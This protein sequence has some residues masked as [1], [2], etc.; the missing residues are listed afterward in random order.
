[1]LHEEILYSTSPPNKMFVLACSLPFKTAVVIID[2]DSQKFKN[3]IHNNRARIQQEINRLDLKSVDDHITTYLAARPAERI[4][5]IAHFSIVNVLI[6]ELSLKQ[7]LFVRNVTILKSSKEYYL[8]Y[9]YSLDKRWKVEKSNL[10]TFMEKYLCP[11]PDHMTDFTIV[12][13]ILKINGRTYKIK[14]SLTSLPVTTS[15]VPLLESRCV[16]SLYEINSNSEKEIYSWIFEFDPF[17]KKN[18]Y[19]FLDEDYLT[20]NTPNKD[21]KRILH[22]LTDEVM[23]MIQSF[24]P[25]DEE[26]VC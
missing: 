9:S 24:H 19:F 21:S 6:S 17:S 4:N 15:D 18:F 22:I 10:T 1:M 11:H 5:M 8:P 26:T 16:L 23:S 13:L 3:W 14:Y 20:I 12:K 7:V 25:F 2:F